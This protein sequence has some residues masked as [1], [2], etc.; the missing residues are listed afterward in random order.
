MSCFKENPK[1]LFIFIYITAQLSGGNFENNF[2][3]VIYLCLKS[4]NILKLIA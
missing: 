2:N 4:C 3:W 1:N